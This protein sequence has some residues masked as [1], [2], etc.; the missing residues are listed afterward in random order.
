MQTPCLVGREA[1][2]GN[3]R[4]AEIQMILQATTVILLKEII[5]LIPHEKV[6][7]LKTS[8]FPN[9]PVGITVNNLS[10]T[11]GNGCNQL[12]QLPLREAAL[13]VEGES[14]QF[15]F[16]GDARLALQT[17]LALVCRQCWLLK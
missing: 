5:M 14:S 3:N 4:W 13:C 2:L 1:V 11:M 16:P 17:S 12:L 9:L 8:F 6:R 7:I 15:R 10:V